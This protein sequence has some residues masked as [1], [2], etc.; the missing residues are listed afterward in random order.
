MTL[1]HLYRSVL[2]R[3]ALIAPAE[4]LAQANRDTPAQ[5]EPLRIAGDAVPGENK[6][7]GH[8]GQP[9]WTARRRFTLGSVYVQPEE[10]FEAEFGW[11][12]AAF[13]SQPD[14]RE[15]NQELEIGLPHRWQLNL[16]SAHRNFREDQ[17]KRHWHHDSAGLGLRHAPAD[18]GKLPLNPTLGVGWKGN[19]GASDAISG[20]LLLATELSPAG[21]GAPPCC[22]S[23][24]P[25]ARAA[26]N[27]PWGQASAFP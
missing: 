20:Q 16:E 5:L 9:E 14:Q 12:R 21:T 22:T 19:S 27:R 17:A 3:L 8:Y 15:F 24:K 6:I 23:D 18:W 25:A 13:A 1:A 10:Q 26:A 2:L 11:Q 4:L 7:I